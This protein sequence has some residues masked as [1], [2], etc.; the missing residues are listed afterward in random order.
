MHNKFKIRLIQTVEKMKK[1]TSNDLTIFVAFF[2]S[3][4]LTKMAV[5]ASK[6]SSK[7]K[8]LMEFFQKFSILAENLVDFDVTCSV[9]LGTVPYW[10]FNPF[11]LLSIICKY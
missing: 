1:N 11:I 7:L 3:C 6:K 8:T 2:H 9:I 10:N 4:L 5:R